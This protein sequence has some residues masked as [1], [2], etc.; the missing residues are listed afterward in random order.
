M[1]RD[2]RR[3]SARLGAHPERRVL[4]PGRRAALRR[5]AG[6]AGPAGDEGAVSPLPPQRRSRRRFVV[7]P[8][9]V[10]MHAAPRPTSPV[11][12]QAILGTS[13]LVIRR[14]RGW[15]LVVTPDRYRGWMRTPALRRDRR[16]MQVVEV[17]SLLANVYA[18]QD[19]TTR[20]PIAVLP[21]LARVEISGAP[22]PTLRAGGTS[23]RRA[24]RVAGAAHEERGGVVGTSDWQRIHLPDG[25][26]GWAQT[27]DLHPPVGKS[28]RRVLS[29]TTG[30]AA[31]IVAT[32][33]RFVGLPYLWGGITTF[34]LDCSGLVQ[35]AH[36]AVGVV[37]PRDADLQWADRRLSPVT[38][39]GI[40]PGDLVFFGPRRGT[41]THVGIA[42]GRRAFVNATTRRR[43]EVRIDRLDD[44]YWKKLFRGARRLPGD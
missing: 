14:S 28:G 42:I 8:P 41:I 32:A 34:G 7:L 25:R 3:R 29:R 15:A 23:P 37:L 38:P 40:R 12:S 43:P 16:H 10:N 22:A 4:T 2:R 35:L 20:A 19:V 31:E 1:N 26:T 18:G 9:V 6:R 39:R 33:L 21:M 5:T 13:V 27:A 44:P 11:V 30:R 24:S 36:R 17:R